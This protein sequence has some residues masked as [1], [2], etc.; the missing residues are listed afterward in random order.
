MR[1]EAILGT[2]ESPIGLSRDEIYDTVNQIAE[3]E[4]LAEV[5]SI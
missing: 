4:L 5:A 2:G 3:V 1:G